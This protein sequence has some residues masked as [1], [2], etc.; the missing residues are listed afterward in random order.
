MRILQAYRARV[1]TS[2]QNGVRAA[3][4][5]RRDPG[6]P[7]A[8]SVSARSDPPGT[9]IA[10][11]GGDPPDSGGRARREVMIHMLEEPP[12]TCRLYVPLRDAGCGVSLRLFRD[13]GGGALR[14]RVHPPR[15]SMVELLGPDQQYYPVDGPLGARTRRATGRHPAHSRS[16]HGGCARTRCRNGCGARRS[17]H[18]C[19]ACAAGTRAQPQ[20]PPAA[21]RRALGLGAQ[22][23]GGRDPRRQRRGRCRSAHVGGA[24]VNVHEPLLEEQAHGV[25]RARVLAARHALAEH[26]GPALRTAT[27]LFGGVRFVRSL[28]T[29][30]TTLRSTSSTKLR[31]GAVPHWRI[32]APCRTPRSTTPPRRSSARRSPAG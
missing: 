21:G 27:I 25:P 4:T 17:L 8:G 30:T 1:P 15:E 16:G 28:P 19:G 22:Q 12:D 24:Q 5:L 23:P 31:C 20:P 26:H 18:A 11:V 3:L 32:A 7:D 2:S 13:R 29:A 6:W 10:S 9:G 14:G